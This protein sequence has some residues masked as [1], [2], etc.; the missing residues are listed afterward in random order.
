MKRFKKQLLVALLVVA[1]PGFAGSA[2]AQ[3][4]SQRVAPPA[5]PLVQATVEPGLSP[6]ERKRKIEH[7]GYRGFPWKKERKKDLLARLREAAQAGRDQEVLDELQYARQGVKLIDAS[8]VDRFS[9]LAR[10][11]QRQQFLKLIEDERKK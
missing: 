11:K 9:V 8:T 7:V 10:A 2:F 1:A 6:K 3:A 4:L 5:R